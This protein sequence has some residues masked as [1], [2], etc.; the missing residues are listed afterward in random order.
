M[1]PENFG[2][3]GTDA[4]LLFLRVTRHNVPPLRLLDFTAEF[5]K[6]AAHIVEQFA[7]EPTLVFAL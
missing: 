5:R 4:R 2:E 3:G 7:L 6:R 1:Y